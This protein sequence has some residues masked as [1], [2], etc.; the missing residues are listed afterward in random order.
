MFMEEAVSN[1]QLAISQEH[2]AT[3]APEKQKAQTL[4]SG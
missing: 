2:G 3:A 4:R 1:R